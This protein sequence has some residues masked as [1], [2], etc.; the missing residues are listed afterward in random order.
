[1][2]VHV[3][4]GHIRNA[5]GKAARGLDYAWRLLRSLRPREHLSGLIQQPRPIPHMGVRNSMRPPCNDAGVIGLRKLKA[6]AL[7]TLGND[8]TVV[9]KSV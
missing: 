4:H 3:S 5:H 8:K 2:P 6:L 7:T 1:M 9:R